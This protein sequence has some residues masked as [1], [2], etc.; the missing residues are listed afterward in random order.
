MLK[1]YIKTSE[2]LKQLRADAR[3][4]VSFEYVIVAACIVGAVVAAFGP[5]S[6][7]TIFTA[8][9]GAITKITDKIAALT[10]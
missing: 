8:L 4:V 3:G 7:G 1:Y 10:V 6:S 2:A 9:S 5:G